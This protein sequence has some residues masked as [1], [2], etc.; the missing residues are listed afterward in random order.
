MKIA[1]IQITTLD[2]PFTPHS[3]QHLQYWI[4]Q[5][6]IVQVCRITLENGVVGWGETL[7]NDMGKIPADIAARIV[8]C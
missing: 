5:W 2:I 1:D 8:G 3:H 4:P 6:R 7:P